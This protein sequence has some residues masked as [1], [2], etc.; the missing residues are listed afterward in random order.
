MKTGSCVLHDNPLLGVR[1]FMKCFQAHAQPFA[2]ILF[3]GWYLFLEQLRPR[4]GRPGDLG[5]RN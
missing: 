2:S 3:P 1:I 5:Q 4:T